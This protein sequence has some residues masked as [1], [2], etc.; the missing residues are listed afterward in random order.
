MPQYVQTSPK[1][2]LFCAIDL[3][4]STENPYNT[5]GTVFAQ[6]NQRRSCP[7]ENEEKYRRAPPGFTPEQWDTFNE[8]GIIF[9]EDAISDEDIVA[10]IDAIDRVAATNP[11]YTP[12]G[13]LGMENIVERDP[14]FTN[15]I[16]HERHVGFA[17]DLFGELL[18]LHQSQFFLR[19]PGG[20][21]YNI[22]H[23]DGARALPYGVF[24]P[25]LPLQI[26]IGY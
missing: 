7:M 23:P 13:Y 22:W 4:N 25:K 14:I 18:K 2:A 6:I 1:Y 10:Y 24:S 12:G 11:K 16:D 26:K 3:Y 21:Q 5:I 19:P 20:K 9:I 8:D 15:L 17:Y